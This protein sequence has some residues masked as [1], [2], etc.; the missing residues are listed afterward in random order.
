MTTHKSRQKADDVK[1]RS[2]TGR[3]VSSGAAGDTRASSVQASARKIKFKATITTWNVRTVLQ[4][5]TF[6]QKGKG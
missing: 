2:A 4:K 3:P 6:K 1:E 5:E